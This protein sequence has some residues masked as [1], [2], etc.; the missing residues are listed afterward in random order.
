MQP[1]VGGISLFIILYTVILI[2]RTVAVLR[3]SY[4]Y[5]PP[6]IIY[7]HTI[8]HSSVATAVH[9]YAYSL[10]KSSISSHVS[11][12]CAA[13]MCDSSTSHLSPWGSIMGSM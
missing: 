9:S 2:E 13:L 11:V 5:Y 4:F 1:L 8:V 12:V 6:G 10:T 3:P 7:T